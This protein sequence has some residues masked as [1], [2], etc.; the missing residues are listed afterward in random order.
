MNVLGSGGIAS[1][2]QHWLKVSGELQAPVASPRGKSHWYP[3]Y[4]WLGGAQTLRRRET[5]R[6]YI[7]LKYRPTL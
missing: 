3:L 4:R 5:I 1:S 6:T 2:L 7:G